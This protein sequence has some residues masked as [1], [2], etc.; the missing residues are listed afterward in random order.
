MNLP[1]NHIWQ[2][3]AESSNRLVIVLHGRGDSAE[4]FIWLQEELALNSLNFLL[5][6]APAPFYTGFSWYG[7]PP[8]QLPGIVQSR[9]VL[10][11]VLAETS[12][13]GYTPSDTFLLGFSQGCLM[14]LEFGAR[15]KDRLAGYI[16]ISGYCYDPQALLRDLNPEVN[17]G[18]WLVTHGTQDDVLPVQETREQVQALRAGGFDIDYREYAKPHTID[19]GRELPD[20]REWMRRRTTS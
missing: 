9:K 20:I 18:D 3:A 2:P 14:T 12:R 1:L 13:S 5:L 10:G 17:H 11:D 4:G 15:H 8:D 7:M 6:T 16:G 19:P